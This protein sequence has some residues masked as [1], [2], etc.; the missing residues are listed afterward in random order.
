MQGYLFYSE[1]L[2][3]KFI[4]FI[5]IL[6]LNSLVLAQKPVIRQP[7][8]FLALGDS[9]TIGQSVPLNDAWPNQ[10]ANY[11]KS[12]SVIVENVS[13]IAQ[14]GWSTS[15]LKDAIR[16]ST[17]PAKTNLV[18]LLIGVNNQYRGLDQKLY[19]T[20]FEELLKTAIQFAGGENYVFVLSI[21]DYGYTPFGSSNQ[22]NIS[23]QIDQ[24]NAINSAITRRY[25][26][27]YF[28]I[29]EISRQ[30]LIM[31]ELLATDG[32]HPS[33]KMYKMWVDLIAKRVEI[34]GGTTAIE[35]NEQAKDSLI[36]IVVDNEFVIVEL[37]REIQDAYFEL[38]DLSGKLITRVR[39]NG[40]TK[41]KL[42][43]PGI[44][45]YTF[46]DKKNKYSG[47]ILVR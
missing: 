37:T 6:L 5:L 14:T 42:K 27:A 40:Q 9:Y 1:M 43:R 19:E 34:K 22:E 2:D 20:E 21:P 44:Y 33:A 38:Y 36:N 35:Q 25:N 7:I 30:G 41:I 45:V 29:T 26:V 8:S 12:K 31:P 24:Y 15:N 13:I 4:T 28:N 32:L 10:F 16:N 23:K 17:I 46:N 39:L 11:L 3:M 47:K 18:S